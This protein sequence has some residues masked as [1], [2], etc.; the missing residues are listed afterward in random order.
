MTVSSNS[1]LSNPDHSLEH[2]NLNSLVEALQALIGIDDSPS[3]STLDYNSRNVNGSSLKDGSITESKLAVELTNLLVPAGTVVGLA[4]ATNNVP[5]GW[6]AL[7]GQTLVG[8]E[9]YYPEL[10]S[11]VP[12]SWKSGS[13]INLPNASSSYIRGASSETLGSKVTIDPP[14]VTLSANDL[15]AHTH[16]SHVS[17]LSHSHGNSVSTGHTHNVSHSHNLPASV[18][19]A[20]GRLN[21]WYPGNQYVGYPFAARAFV[22]TQSALLNSSN[23]MTLNGNGLTSYTTYNIGM[24]GIN[25]VG[26]MQVAY[27]NTPSHFQKLDLILIIKVH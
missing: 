16:P 1:P 12:S 7:L 11:I 21:R 19:A 15:P 5:L 10:W 6:A 25:T 8:A 14:A 27:G 13:N 18:S 2:S 24:S 26:N 4:S 22:N 17:T 23:S 9:T 20:T 3:S